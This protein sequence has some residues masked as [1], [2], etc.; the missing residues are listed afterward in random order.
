MPSAA[1]GSMIGIA[2]IAGEELGALAL[3][4]FG[5]DFGAVHDSL[6]A[7]SWRV[8]MRRGRAETGGNA[9]FGGDRRVAADELLHGVDERHVFS[10]LEPAG[11]H[12]VTRRI[13]ARQRL[14]GGVVLQRLQQQPPDLDDRR[15]RGEQCSLARSAIGPIDS[16]MAQSCVP[17]PFMPVYDLPLACSS[18]SIR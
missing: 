9:L 5:N 15:V 4:D 10:C 17:N 13:H 16:W 14:T 7:I 1:Q 18:R 8:T 6:L 11:A 2:R 12:P 3:E